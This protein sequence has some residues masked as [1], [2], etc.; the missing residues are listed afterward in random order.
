M[1]KYYKTFPR[2]R[3]YDLYKIPKKIGIGCSKELEINIPEKD[4]A[5]IILS[6]PF[7]FFLMVLFLI[8]LKI[9]KGQND[10][11]N[12]YYELKEVFRGKIQA[13]IH[14]KEIIKE[15]EDKINQSH[16]AKKNLGITSIE[17]FDKEII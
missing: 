15:I 3:L 12:L 1:L 7:T 11:I 2:N 9:F 10:Y 14:M 13:I 6:F 8:F 16:L 17:T 4:V 5:L